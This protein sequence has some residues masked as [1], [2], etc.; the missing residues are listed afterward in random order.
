MLAGVAAH[1]THFITVHAL[2]SHKLCGKFVAMNRFLGAVAE[3][4]GQKAVSSTHGAGRTRIRAL[5]KQV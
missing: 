2:E 5:H 4:A 1:K 3:G